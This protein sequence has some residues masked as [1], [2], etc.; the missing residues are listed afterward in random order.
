MMRPQ[1]PDRGSIT[2]E[3][4]LI[5]PVILLVLGLTGMGGRV[6]SAHSQVEGAARDAARAASISRGDARA[7]ATKAA[8]DALDYHDADHNCVG[9]PTVSLNA[10][11]TPNEPVIATVTCTVDLSGLGL[12]FATK[13]V[14]EQVTSPVD[15]YVNR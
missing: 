3:A 10:D 12:P 11:P 2:L 15:Q 4:T 7:D 9:G 5:A 6:A 1:H 14:T 13:K 8:T